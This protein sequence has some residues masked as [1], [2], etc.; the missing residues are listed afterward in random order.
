MFNPTRDQARLFFLNSWKKYHKEEPLT[1]AESLALQWMTKHPEYFDI[2][3]AEPE[4]ILAADFS[5]EAGQ[6]NPFLHLS[7]HL[8]VAEQVS[9]DQPPGIR[10]AFAKL[11][12]KMGDD[13][14]A[15]HQVFEC[16][17]E[18]IYQQQKNGVA[19]SSENYIQC[20]LEHSGV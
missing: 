13:H 5:V 2:F 9:I 4:S 16:L 17:A 12:E 1:E 3:D 7:M 8:A 15:A 20:I 10:A 6:S 11:C 18:Q 19:F 14:K